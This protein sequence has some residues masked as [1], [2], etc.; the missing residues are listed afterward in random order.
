MNQRLII[1]LAA[2]SLGAIAAFALAVWRRPS[3]VFLLLALFGM[4]ASAQTVVQTPN[5]STF[6]DSSRAINWSSAGF[7]IPSYSVNCKTQPS[8]TA[9]SSAASANSTSIQNALNSCDSTHNVVSI[10]AGTFYFTSVTFGYQGHQVLRGAG[11][12]LTTLI[13]TTGVGCSG[14]LSAG[15]C[16]IDQNNVYGGSSLVMPSGSQQCLWTAGYSQGTTSIT[17][18]SC[19]GAPPV[20]SIVVLDQANDT[21]DN[22]GVYIC[23]TNIVNCGVEGTTGG[24]NNGRFISGVTHSQQQLT[25]ITAVS[26]S[27]PYT[28]TISPGVYFTNVR[29]SQSPD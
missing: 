19:G 22:N 29:S 20:N 17:L 27:G 18:S 23:D 12:A 11:P 8:L 15:L 24:N 7:T 16:M 14:G 25:K 6:L 21:S 3:G 26:G 4:G 10:P 13:P 2:L 5:W 9:G 1:L 28:V